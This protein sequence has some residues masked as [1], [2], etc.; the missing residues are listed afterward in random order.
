MTNKY[1]VFIKDP[2]TSEIWEV[3]PKSYNFDEEVSKGF[4]ATFTFSLQELEILAETNNTTTENIFTAS[5]REIYINRNGSKIFYGVVSNY[6]VS[7]GTNGDDTLT[8]KAVGFLDL[9]KKALVGITEK[10]YFNNVDAGLI[11]WGLIN[12]YQLSDP[13]YSDRGITQGTIQTSKNRDRGYRIDNVYDQLMK[14]TNNNLA[15]GIDIEIDNT[16]KYNAYSPFKGVSRPTVVFDKNTG[17]GWSYEKQL[18]LDMTNQAVVVGEGTNEQT[19]YSVRTASTSYRSQFGTLMTK[20]TADNT[21]G[22]DT[23][24]DKGDKELTEN[25]EPMVLVKGVSH[26][27]DLIA[28]SDYNVGDIVVLNYPTVGIINQSKRIKK[29]NFKMATPNSIAECKLEFY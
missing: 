8:I 15:N 3:I 10:L 17:W 2:A 27:D 14:L 22:D 19:I 28:F 16:K 26:Y 29:R 24:E 20:L 12:A 13:P 21:T 1:E 23:L 6:A 7:P 25:Q 4:G 18:F 5:L 11:G 9:F